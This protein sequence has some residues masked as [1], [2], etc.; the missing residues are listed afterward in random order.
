MRSMKETAS[1]S[2]ILV[3]I[4]AVSYYSTGIYHARATVTKP[5]TIT[6]LRWPQYLYTVFTSQ[7]PAKKP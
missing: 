3:N 4:N 5:K 7:M 2:N 1:D 6:N